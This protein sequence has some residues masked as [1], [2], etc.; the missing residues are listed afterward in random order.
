[1]K[2]SGFITIFCVNSF[3]RELYVSIKLLFQD[4][5]VTVFENGNL[6]KDYTFDEIRERAEI[7]QVRNYKAR[8]Q[9]KKC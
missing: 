3:E 2:C 7:V 6:L 8:Q 4:V 1:M 5:L 9:Q